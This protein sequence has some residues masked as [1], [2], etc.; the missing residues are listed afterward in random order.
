MY[1]DVDPGTSMTHNYYVRVLLLRT[2]GGRKF[3]VRL[4]YA[5]VGIHDMTVYYS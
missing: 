1:P 4:Q 3:T 5:H 2:Q